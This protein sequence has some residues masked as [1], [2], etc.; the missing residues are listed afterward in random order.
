M[1]KIICDMCGTSYPSTASQCPICG[2]S[3]PE[4]PQVDNSQSEESREGKYTHV[5]GGRFSK[6]N[7]RKRNNMAKAVPVYVEDEHEDEQP[8][9]SN[10][11]LT[12]AIIVLTLAIIAVAIYIYVRFFAPGDPHNDYV[13]P[14][15]T[16]TAGTTVAQTTPTPSSDPGTTPAPTPS[17]E[18][19]TTPQPT[20]TPPE[21]TAPVACTDLNLDNDEK[22]LLSELGETVQLVVTA[23]PADTTY[24]I[25]YTSSDVNVATVDGSGKVTAVAEG[26]TT[27]TIS[28]GDKVVQCIVDVIPP[29]GKTYKLNKTDVTMYAKTPDNAFTIQLRDENGKAVDGIV[30]E[31]SN[32]RVCTV[33]DVG[34]VKYV[35]KGTAKIT[36]TYRG[37]TYECIIRA[38]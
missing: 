19:E 11:G 3:K 16:F 29:D 5:K 33:N 18:P 14:N 25:I 31:S 21:T 26:T 27:I 17:S 37:V 20:T 34:Y 10:R 38:G 9:E 28:C 22:I 23:S 36:C 7:V 12:I 15:P 24:A 32:E 4:N 30:W 13:K 35:G 6:A 8:V 1:N 2:C